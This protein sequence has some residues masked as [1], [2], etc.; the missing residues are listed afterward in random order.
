MVLV[1]RSLLN[2][3][4]EICLEIFESSFQSDSKEALLGLKDSLRELISSQTQ[5]ELLYV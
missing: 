5:E 4:R 3:D 1:L 2:E